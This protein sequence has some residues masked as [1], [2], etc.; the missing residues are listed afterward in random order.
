[1]IDFTLELWLLVVA[2]ITSALLGSRLWRMTRQEQAQRHRLDKFRRTSVTSRD[3][4]WYRRIGTQIV[5]SPVVGVVERQRLFKLLLAAGIKSRGN[6]ANFLAIKACGAAIFAALVWLVLGWTQPEDIWFWVG[7]L[8]IAS[9]VGWRVPDIILGRLVKRRRLRVEQG[10]P[11]ALDLLVI[12]AEAGLSLNQ[13]IGEV[14]R[15]LRRSNKD[16]AEEFDATAAEMQ[17]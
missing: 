6:L 15:Q 16:V 1:M 7:G 8:G 3:S 5:L 2:V 11:D 14:G 17:V 10:I 4:S 12:C 13:A 9:L